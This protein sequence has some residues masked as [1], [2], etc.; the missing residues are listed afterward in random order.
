MWVV[1]VRPEQR[2]AAGEGT[3]AV[4]GVI[5]SEAHLG[6]SQVTV[7]IP[8]RV[9]GKRAPAFSPKDGLP[10]DLGKRAGVP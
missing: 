6:A 7:Y 1:S 3:V 10:C 8:Y 9:T 5:Q 4:V 2:Q